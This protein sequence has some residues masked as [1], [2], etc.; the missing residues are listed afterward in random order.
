M[1]LRINVCHIYL[2]VVLL[3]AVDGWLYPGGGFLLKH[4]NT[5]LL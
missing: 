3:C 5:F 1:K 2:L 4:F